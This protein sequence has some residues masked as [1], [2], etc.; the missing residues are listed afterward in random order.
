MRS[1]VDEPIYRIWLEPLEALDITSETLR[2]RAPVQISSWVQDRFGP[3]L[4]DCA[5]QVLGR[6]IG[7]DLTAGEGNEDPSGKNMLLGSLDA[8]TER[9]PFHPKLTFDQFVIGDSN[10]L[11]HAAA[12]AVAEMPSHAYNPLFICGP[13]G[14]G[15]THLLHSIGELVRTHNPGLSVRLSTG[16]TFTNE[17]QRALATGRVE[18][19]KASFR[20][21]DV[22]LLDDVQFF[23]RKA[24]TEEEFFHTFN[25][26]HEIG[27]QV[28]LTSDRPPKD[29]QALEDRLRE[30]FQ[31]G[32]VADISPPELATR[33]AIL[34]KRAQRDD[35]PMSDLGVLTFIAQH[36]QTNVRALEGALIRVIAYSSLTGRALTT[37]LADDVL[38]RLYPQ[39]A[40]GTR[41]GAPP[42][43]DTIQAAVCKR[44]EISLEELLSPSR[45]TRIALPRQIAMYL[46]RELT[47]ESFPAIGRSFGGRDHSTALYAC[48]Q[49]KQRIND[50]EALKRT[51]ENLRIDLGENNLDRR[52]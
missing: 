26:L 49:A 19:F 16:E 39:A 7:L 27:S 5:A 23:E 43:T 14:V 12:L 44:F 32:L 4:R 48:R 33:V 46:T 29:L 35:L 18:H 3:L 15:K 47:K 11:A 6:Q 34:R 38:S 17:F 21:L 45:S 42:S 50:N 1:A 37:E 30:R 51:V 13:P 52:P 31:A 20:H 8:S 10:R 40:T 22:L 41:R 36:V 25:A 2:L 9:C 24:K 28:V